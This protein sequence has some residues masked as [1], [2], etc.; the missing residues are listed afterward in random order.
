MGGRK[1]GL[2]NQPNPMLEKKLW[3]VY[4]ISTDNMGQSNMTKIGSVMAETHPDAQAAA[5]NE[6]G[7]HRVSYV[8]DDWGRNKRV[9][10]HAE[11]GR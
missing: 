6:Y 8:E 10:T 4:S 2:I 1:M 5:Y 7:P 3:S 11:E 9:L